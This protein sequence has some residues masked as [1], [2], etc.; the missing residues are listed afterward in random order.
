M[1]VTFEIQTTLSNITFIIIVEVA[2][3]IAVLN[4]VNLPDISNIRLFLL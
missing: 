3:Q 2:G 1:E 4:H